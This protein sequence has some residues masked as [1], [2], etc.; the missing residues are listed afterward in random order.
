LSYAH[1]HLSRQA[2]TQ[3]LREAAEL[4]LYPPAS[5]NKDGADFIKG[6]KIKKQSKLKLRLPSYFLNIKINFFSSL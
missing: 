1:R 4:F 3:Q 6:I 2:Q 5:R